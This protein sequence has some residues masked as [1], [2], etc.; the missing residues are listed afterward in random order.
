MPYKIVKFKK[1]Y[2]VKLDKLGR[3]V[4]F[5]NHLLTYIEALNQLKALYANVK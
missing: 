1:G 2:K 4:Y 5:S 3:P